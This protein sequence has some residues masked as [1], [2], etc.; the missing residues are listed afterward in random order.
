MKKTKDIDNVFSFRE[1]IRKTDVRNLRDLASSTGFF[2]KEEIDIAGELAEERLSKGTGS[3][4][5]FIIA[6]A[7]GMVCGYTCFGLIPCTLTSFDLYWIVVSPVLQGKGLGKK[8][9]QLTEQKI[10]SMGG[11][12]VYADTSSRM[13]YRPTRSFYRKAGYRKVA[14]IKDFYAP[15]DGK[16]IF[17]KILRK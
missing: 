3:G 13:Q 11:D 9:I 6:E 16:C 7:G 4:Y 14:V 17:E 8:L 5:H 1:R 12:R 10:R 15:G 2:S